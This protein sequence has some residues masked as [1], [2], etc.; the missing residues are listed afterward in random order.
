MGYMNNKIIWLKRMKLILI[1]IIVAVKFSA[2]KSISKRLAK[3]T[4]KI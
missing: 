4:I 2:S 3:M 1:Y